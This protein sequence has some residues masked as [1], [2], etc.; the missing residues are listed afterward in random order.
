MET[1]G[2]GGKGGSTRKKPKL[3]PIFNVT[4]KAGN[5]KSVNVI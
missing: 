4:S 1:I 5:G 3:A 2:K